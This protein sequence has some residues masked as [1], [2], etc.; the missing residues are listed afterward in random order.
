MDAY[1]A[2]KGD[3]YMYYDPEP[4]ATNTPNPATPYNPSDA[5]EAEKA[6]AESTASGD[7][8]YTEEKEAERNPKGIVRGTLIASQVEQYQKDQQTYNDYASQ[9]LGRPVVVD[10]L[11]SDERS[12]VNTTLKSLGIE[13]PRMGDELYAYVKWAEL[14]GGGD[15]SVSSYLQWFDQ[16]PDMTQQDPYGDQQPEEEEVPAA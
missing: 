16:Q 1:F 14:Q 8:S 7:G 10:D 12:A 4:I 6:A 15:T 13:K 3:K 5:I 11:P 9:L 2:Y